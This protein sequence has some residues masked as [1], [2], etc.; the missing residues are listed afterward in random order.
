MIAHDSEGCDLSNPRNWRTRSSIHVVMDGIHFQV[1]A[2]PEFRL[3][4]IRNN[5][6]QIDYF[7]LTHRHADHIMG[8]DDLRRFCDLKDFSALPVYSSEDGL[9]RIREVY[10]YAIGDKPVHKGYAAFQ[11]NRIPTEWNT[12][13]GKIRHT[14]LEHGNLRVLGLVFEE[15]SSGKKFAY[16][17]DCKRVDSASI[18]LARGADVVV[19]DGLRPEPHPTHMSID[20]AVAVARE[21]GAPQTYLTH[22]TFKIDYACWQKKLSA[23][24]DLA[25]DGLAIRL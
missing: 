22:M 10:A 25:W 15:S 4:C 18:Q 5:I 6:R 1:D 19:L 23:G 8:M 16:Y 14:L 9:A 20:E 2:A 7:I 13:G 21:I 11:L 17:C 24:V 3:Q 12:P